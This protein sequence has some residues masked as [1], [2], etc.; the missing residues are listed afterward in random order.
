MRAAHE[1]RAEVMKLNT[2]EFRSFT[3]GGPVSKSPLL[4][5]PFVSPHIKYYRPPLPSPLF[6]PWCDA[7]PGE[8]TPSP[9]K[10]RLSC[11]MINP[12]HLSVPHYTTLHHTTFAI[13]HTTLRYALLFQCT[14]HF[15]TFVVI[16]PT[17]HTTPHYTTPH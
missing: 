6:P 15:T 4:L 17:H 16:N 10:R 5:L 13:H 8:A 2:A 1:I 9:T 14:L 11:P 3:R 7:G 12:P